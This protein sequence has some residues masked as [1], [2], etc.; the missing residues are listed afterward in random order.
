M[1]KLSSTIRH[2][3]KGKIYLIPKYVIDSGF[4]LI[5][6]KSKEIIKTSKMDGLKAYN[7]SDLLEILTKT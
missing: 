6:Y 2:L 3:K 4:K 1:L 7:E 5:G